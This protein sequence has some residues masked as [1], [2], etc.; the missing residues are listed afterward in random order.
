[1]VEIMTDQMIIRQYILYDLFFSF[2]CLAFEKKQTF[3]SLESVTCLD[4][5]IL[6]EVGPSN[7]GLTWLII[8]QLFK[9]GVVHGACQT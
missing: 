7:F 5:P 1:M 8:L 9:A 4:S 3:N 6:G 2:T